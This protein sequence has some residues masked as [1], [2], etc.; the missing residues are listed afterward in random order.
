MIK[1]NPEV[2]GSNHTIGDTLML[3]IGDTGE[4]SG[5]LGTWTAFR[6]CLINEQVLL[7]EYRGVF[8]R[9]GCCDCYESDATSI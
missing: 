6:T 4:K 1:G 7:H 3:L 5:N 2:M 9:C 8:Q